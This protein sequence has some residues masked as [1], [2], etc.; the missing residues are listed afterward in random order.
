LGF[1]FSREQGGSREVKEM[2]FISDATV[3]NIVS[4]INRFK[5]HEEKL[6]KQEEQNK[7][8]WRETFAKGRHAAEG[9]AGAALIGFLHG[10]YEDADSNFFI[11]RTSIPADITLGLGSTLL[12]FLFSMPTEAEKADSEGK[13][14]KT[15][16]TSAVADD[17]FALSNG[18]MNGALAMYFR[19]HAL[20]GRQAD[21][22]WAGAP[23]L[24]GAPTHNHPSIGAAMSDTEL[25]AV[26]RRTL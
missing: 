15:D 12:T 1:S 24:V 2:P 4:K 13:S 11:P 7:I 10:R 19:K 8:K 23:E 9:M 20:A 26:L 21:K 5:A 25:A 6:E 14:K 22:F 17:L 16:T 3:S 18:L